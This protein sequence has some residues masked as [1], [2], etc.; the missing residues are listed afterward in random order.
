MPQARLFCLC[1]LH[2]S[3][4]RSNCALHN[5]VTT[6][7][8]TNQRTVALKRHLHAMRASTQLQGVFVWSYDGSVPR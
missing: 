5:G 8:D 2:G 1:G 4:F 3:T 7:H 6:M